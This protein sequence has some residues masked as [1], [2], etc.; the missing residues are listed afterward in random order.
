MS[1]RFR[2]GILGLVVGIALTL[3][4]PS[5]GQPSGTPPASG[6]QRTVKVSGS[7]IIRSQP[8]EAVISIGVQT[9]DRTANQAL[10]DNAAKMAKAIN[11]VVAAGV[12]RSDIDTSF[13]NLNPNY[14]S[15]GRTVDSY[16]AMNQVEVTVRDLTKV[17]HVI[18][19]A[20]SAGA[21][22]AG[23]IT[24]KLSNEN[25]GRPDA[26]AAAVQDARS[27]AEALAAAAGAHLGQVVSIEQ[28]SSEL[29]PPIFDERGKAD[30]AS[31]TPV[32]PPTLEAQVSVT[33]VW[34]LT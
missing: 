14:D 21:N 34:A 15:S 27:Q 20:V 32:F 9:Q 16:I 6:T 26:L 33:V 13:I 11:A 12:S 7:A 18:D 25:K 28:T 8:D 10:R 23:G 3:A 31:P 17:G 22:L 19:R 30:I 29:P 5:L 24:F 2:W 1:T 4:L